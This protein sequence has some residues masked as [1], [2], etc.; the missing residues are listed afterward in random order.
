MDPLKVYFI[1]NAFLLAMSGYIFFKTKPDLM[2]KREFTV[3]R[4]FIIAFWF[5]IIANSIWTMQEYDII[6][7]PMYLFKIVCFISLSLVLLNG[8]CFYKFTMIYFGYSD[9][10]KLHYEIFSMI[11]YII[12]EI[13]LFISIWNGL[14]FSV[15]EDK[16]IVL[17]PLYIIMMVTAFLYFLVILVSSVVEMFRSKTKQAKRSCF[18]LFILVVFLILWIVLDYFLNSL[19]IIPLAIFG[20]IFVLFITFQNSSINTDSLTQ[21]NNRRRAF[22]Y[23]PSQ[24]DNVSEDNPLGLYLIDIDYFKIINDKYGHLE[25]DSALVILADSIK[26]V[27]KSYNGFCAR[28]GGDEFIFAAR[29]NGNLDECEIINKIQILV[30]SK[31]R[32]LNKEYNINL[33]Y[34][35]VKC[36][37]HRVNVES[38]LREVDGLLY[39][40]K[41]NRGK[42]K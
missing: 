28:Y 13:L 12:T 29:F 31:C 34:G 39:V 24:L 40:Q 19:T 37:D 5:Y 10:R 18:T 25:G 9:K 30:N 7:L 11:P 36:V 22:E 42:N 6:Q 26:E 33:S 32:L 3:F 41:A 14:M 38:Y 16:N 20:V 8:V 23:L 4:N 27:A 35:F 15:S 2:K 21:M 17:G 1:F